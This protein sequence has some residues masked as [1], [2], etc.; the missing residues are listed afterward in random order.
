MFATIQLIIRVWDLI[1]TL[2]N[3]YK[4]RDAAN[5]DKLIE[6]D[7]A[8]YTALAQAKTPEEVK[9]AEKDVARGW[10]GK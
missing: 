6:R 3:T 8:A 10:F 7:L 5:W 2:I 1:T 4:A 9:H